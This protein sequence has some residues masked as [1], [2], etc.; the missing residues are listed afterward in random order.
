MSFGF[1]HFCAGVVCAIK[2]R[3]EISTRYLP[4]IVLLYTA[5]GLLIA[6]TAGNISGTKKI[7]FFSFF[8]SFWS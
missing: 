3:K 2:L 4:L 7:F 6:V 8:F 5:L 1:T